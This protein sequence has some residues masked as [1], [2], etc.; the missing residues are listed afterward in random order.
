MEGPRNKP[1]RPHCGAGLSDLGM[2]SPLS[3][4]HSQGSCVWCLSHEE[5]LGCDLAWAT[6]SEGGSGTAS[7]GR[8]GALSALGGWQG[9]RR[10]WSHESPDPVTGGSRRPPASST[11]VLVY[12]FSSAVIVTVT[13][14]RREVGG[15]AGREGRRTAWGF[16][17]P[18]TCGGPHPHQG[19]LGWHESS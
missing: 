6:P 5:T 3:L 15:W 7:R 14:S 1:P 8:R 9:G 4:H 12:G 2:A 11:G 18:S 17:N 10:P 13:R 19:R 16:P